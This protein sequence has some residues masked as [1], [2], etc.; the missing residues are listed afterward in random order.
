MTNERDTLVEKLF[1]QAIDLPEA[2]RASF[3]AARSEGDDELAREVLHL[4]A[5]YGQ[6]KGGFLDGV[7][8]RMPSDPSPEDAKAPRRIGPYTIERELGAGGMGIVYLARQESPVR[9]NV[10]LKVLRPGIDTRSVL[11]RFEAERELLAAMEHPGI[12]RVLDAG[13]TE[14][15]RPYFVMEYVRGEP[16]T[17]WCDT[18][19]LDVRARLELFLLIC[20]AVQ[21]AHIKGVA[22]RDLKPSN[23]LVSE[24]DGS[25]VPKVIDFG[26]AKALGESPDG[27]ATLTRRGDLV[28]TPEYM[29][30]EQAGVGALDVDTRTDV[31]SLGVVLYRLL[32]GALPFDRALFRGAPSEEIRRILTE[33]NVPKPSTRSESR[34]AS[35]AENESGAG[36]GE[37]SEQRDDR[38]RRE[39]RERARLLRGDLDWIVLK[40]VERDRER[41]YESPRALAED[42][43]RHLRDE[44][45]LAGPPRVTYRLAK[46]VK[47]N[48]TALAVA[49]SIAFGLL[50]GAAGLLYALLESNRQRAMAE[51]AREES[52]A[53]TAFLSQTLSAASPMFEGIAVTVEE[54][55]DDAARTMQS[56]FSDRPLLSARL[57]STL[58]SAFVAMGDYESGEA[59][60]THALA[61]REQI[62]GPNDDATLQ[63]MYELGDLRSRQGRAAEAESLLTTTFRERRAAFGAHATETRAAALLLG[64]H[65]YRVGRAEEAESLFARAAMA[66]PLPE[67]G[68]DSFTAE[69]HEI[70]IDAVNG[71]AVLRRRATDYE[72]AESLLTRSLAICDVELRPDHPL[73]I[74]TWNNFAVLYA[75]TDRPARAE[76]LY[77]RVLDAQRRIAGEDHPT[78]W[79][80]MSNLATFYANHERLSE[81]ESLHAAVLAKRTA[82]LGEDHA[83]VLR[84]RPHLGVLYHRQRDLERARKTLES[85]VEARRALFGDE[86]DKVLHS[87]VALAEVLRDAGRFAEAEQLYR[88]VLADR[89]ASLGEDHRYVAYDEMRLG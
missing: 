71:L 27:G 32:T 51:A 59:Q 23:I 12:A 16:V 66:V 40:A 9:R 19:A 10:A 60:L 37:V 25:P 43:R 83:I 1:Q 67:E 72:A 22:H 89:T 79:I 85:V 77:V 61:T 78:T 58:G 45:V 15:G 4:I 68:P 6:A 87:S 62:L 74:L 8:A 56:E 11:A 53:V 2:E 39:G 73:T 48:R 31:Y 76:S 13:E 3:V 34:A 63:S 52:E 69:D 57:A 50:A 28:G 88:D 65:Y 80:A 81:A 33:E 70:T 17:T 46:F 82:L 30:P 84:T 54:V 21:H 24:V 35:R 75:R 29:S 55:L 38:E 86:Y 47:R 42:I 64:T 26:I 7:A 36:G 49:G 5:H 41:R 20:E 14:R 18:H 44:P